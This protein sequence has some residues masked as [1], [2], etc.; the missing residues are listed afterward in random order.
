M[1]VAVMINKP[2]PEGKGFQVGD[3]P[4]RGLNLIANHFDLTGLFHYAD[5]LC[6]LSRLGNKSGIW[7]ANRH[8]K[9]SAEK[10]PNPGDSLN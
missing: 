7:Q 2:G 1:R 10:L 6:N 3:G 9:M 8:R 4:L 5:Q